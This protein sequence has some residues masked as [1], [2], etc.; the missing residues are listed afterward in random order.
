MIPSNKAE[1]V[2]PCLVPPETVFVVSQVVAS[3]AAELF[4]AEKETPVRF[5][6]SELCKCFVSDAS[7]FHAEDGAV[8]RKQAEHCHFLAYT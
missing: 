2:Y 7:H 6:F 1:N 8:K 5:C 3:A 4:I